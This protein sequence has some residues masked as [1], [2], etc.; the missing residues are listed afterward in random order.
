M[1]ASTRQLKTI[2][3]VFGFGL[4]M[5]SPVLI[6]I[7]SASRSTLSPDDYNMF[8]GF[9]LYLVIH[10][11]I[12]GALIGSGIV[13]A[14]M[15]SCKIWISI[16]I[17]L[18]RMLRVSLAVCLLVSVILGVLVSILLGYVPVANDFFHWIEGR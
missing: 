7:I 11:F 1:I 3:F 16:R 6:E 14:A 15:L 17:V 5:A 18:D 10:H 12:V 13:L 4:G 8:M 2:A 9:A